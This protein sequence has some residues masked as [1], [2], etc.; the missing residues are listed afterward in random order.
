[1]GTIRV[2]ARTIGLILLGAHFAGAAAAAERVS[3]PFDCRYDG[4]RVDLAPSAD[5]SYIILGS[6]ESEIFSACSPADPNRCRSWFVHRF[7]MECNGSRVAWADV[8]AAAMR[9]YGKPGWV[10]NGRFHLR[11]GPMWTFEGRDAFRE[12]QRRWLRERDAPA[13]RF[14]GYDEDGRAY[15]DGRVV[16]LPAGFAPAQG[17]PV[18]FSGVPNDPAPVAAVTMPP[19]S[20]VR[21]PTP[22]AEVAPPRTLRSAQ[23]VAALTSPPKPEPVPEL[24][25][26]A[27]RR[28][29]AAAMAAQAT[30]A[31]AAPQKPATAPKVAM[32]E[33]AKPA[34]PS[35]PSSAPVTSKADEAEPAEPAS[36][37]PALTIINGPQSKKQPEPQAEHESDQAVASD[38]AEAP[39]TKTAEPAT[40]DIST[41]SNKAP[42]KEEVVAAADPVASESPAPTSFAPAPPAKEKTIITPVTVAAA[43]ALALAA[44][45]A[46]IGLRRRTPE[47][48][49][50]TPPSSRDYGSISLGGFSPAASP[51][52]IRGSLSVR[53]DPE[54]PSIASTP[55]APSDSLTVAPDFPVPASYEQALDVLGVSPDASLAAIKKIVDGLRL[56][57]HPD[58]ARS[59]ADR[60]YRESR[61]RQ[62]NVAWDLVSEHRSAA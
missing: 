58:H 7:E 29:I 21:S 24:P 18:A 23:P 26:R 34:A 32:A 6:H 55:T 61:S 57:W 1:M 10:E 48:V 30:A 39:V 60:L 62:I 49:H 20:A 42:A 13:D 11:M 16:T 53:A 33:A 36:K 4:A 43:L 25:E 45:A 22:V 31:A 41:G 52:A 5:R 15:R 54:P 40:S 2:R 17:I 56:S 38:V 28:E 12:G 8:A 37:P 35:A 3:M 51:P 27:P 46:T 59:E 19:P 44:L 47:L 9:Y 14:G 50:V